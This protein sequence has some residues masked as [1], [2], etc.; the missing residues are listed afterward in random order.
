[1]HRTIFTTPVLSGLLHWLSRFSLWLFGW[2]IVGKMPDIPKFVVI[3]APHTSNWDFP[4]TLAAA[5]SLKA[6]ILWMGKDSLFKS[7]LGAIY[8]WLGGISVD[9]SRS[10]N[11]VGRA[12]EAFHQAE[13]LVLLV[14]PEG[15]RQKARYWK[16]GFY[17]IASGA[18][19]PIVMAF[20]DYGRK[21]AGIGPTLIP[22][23]DI[24]ADMEQIQSFY[25]GI[26]GKHPR[27]YGAVAV[28]PSDEQFVPEGPPVQE[29]VNLA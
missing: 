20:M 14:P 24:H 1:M 9:R 3:A 2:R 7:P 12:V 5:F 10:T 15:T 28:R 23:G 8:R 18:G 22:T 11:L 19:V 17:F 6:Q 26:E 13:R 16:T 29:P 21:V 4:I 27:F 25:S